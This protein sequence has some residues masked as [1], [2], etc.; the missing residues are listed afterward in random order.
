MTQALKA[1]DQR[2]AMQDS[3]LA[4]SAEERF[5][6]ATI[7]KGVRGNRFCERDLSS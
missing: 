1:P 7:Q 5:L 4:L 3:L 2:A 6:L